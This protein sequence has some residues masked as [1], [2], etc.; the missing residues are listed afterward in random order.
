MFCKKCGHELK[1]NVAFCTYCGQPVKGGTQP[2]K[3]EQPAGYE[4]AEK[5]EQQM[6][7]GQPAKKKK[8]LWLVPI[9]VMAVIAAALA[10]FVVYLIW[11][12]G[13][14]ED[15]S[16]EKETFVEAGEAE[17]EAKSEGGAEEGRDTPESAGDEEASAVLT[18]DV[19]VVS[20]DVS[21]YPFVKVYL[22]VD[23]PQT[24]EMVESLGA[25]AFSVSER[26][27][28]GEYLAREVRSAGI[29]D[30]NQGLNIVLAADK[31]GSIDPE[32]MDQI[33]QVMEDFVLS[34]NYNA[35]DKAEVL[36]FDSIVQQM[37][38][39]TNDSSLLINGIHNMFSDGSTALY[40]ALYTGI[41]HAGLQGGARCVAAYTAGTDGVSSHTPEQVIEYALAKQVPVYLIGVGD[42]VDESIL[43]NIAESTGG[44]FWHITEPHELEQAFHE[45]YTEQKKLYVVEYESDSSADSGQRRQLD[46]R[47][48]GNGYQGGTEFGFEPVH[49]LGDVEHASRYEVFKEDLTWEQAAQRCREMGGHLAT[50]TS[51]EEQETLIGMAEDAGIDFVW[52]GGYT[53]YD[54]GGNVFGHWM[55]GEVFSYAAWCQG[56]PSRADQDGTEERYIMLWN[57]PSLGGWTWNDQRNDPAM[58]SE[59]MKGSM[60]YICEFDG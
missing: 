55:T 40:D 41:D 3:E 17:G 26:L 13:Q 50:V 19:Q 51:Q 32:D 53:S 48:S 43:R 37:C 5:E 45:L 30:G 60:G 16:R 34:L 35:G 44:R 52:L 57:I 46:I 29:L 8:S 15:S 18:A 21:S 2:K 47:V 1:E 10:A 9:V 4:G 56:E 24:Q 59:A 6:E 39:Y 38:A 58:A 12:K 54:R 7:G 11:A 49:F 28:G 23:D 22:R 36:A 27:E 33:K 42:S 20:T 25:E 31:S 14:E